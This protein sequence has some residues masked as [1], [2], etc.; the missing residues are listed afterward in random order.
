MPV[1]T[2]RSE[3]WVRAFVDETAVVDSRAPMLF[4]EERR[5]VPHYAFEQ[6][7][8]RMDLL[9]TRDRPA[10]YHRFFGPGGPVT[11]WFDVEVGEQVLA[12]AAW[13]RDTPELADLVILT[14]EPG[15]VIRWMEED[16]IVFGHPRDPHKRVDALP[17]SRHVTVSL[18]GQVLAESHDPVVLFET[19]LPTRYYLRQQDL[20]SA[21]LKPTNHET[22]CPYKGVADRYWS[23]PGAENIAWSYTFPVPAVQHIAERVAFYN[24]FVDLVVDGVQQPRPTTPFSA[25]RP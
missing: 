2:E 20:V 8:V 4:W 25:G 9:T 21:E 15:V 7:D 1:R 3:R 17:S 22:V 18:D 13:I 10:A 16:E 23:A 19:G 12:A 5:P 14:W 6:A 11:Q 24:E